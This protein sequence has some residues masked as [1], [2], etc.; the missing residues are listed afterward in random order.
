MAQKLVS[1]ILQMNIVMWCSVFWNAFKVS[2]APDA[3]SRL[4]FFLTWENIAWRKLLFAWGSNLRKIFANF[5][6][7]FSFFGCGVRRRCRG[8]M[9]VLSVWKV[10][11]SPVSVFLSRYD[12]GFLPPCAWLFFDDG[13][14]GNE[15]EEDQAEAVEDVPFQ[16]WELA[17]W[18]GRAPDNW[19]KQGWGQK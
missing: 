18:A 5:F 12:F 17:V 19:R 6:G 14:S 9:M 10:S 11:P 2:D 8:M 1:C 13:R 7:L 16:H 3:T 15:L 4:F